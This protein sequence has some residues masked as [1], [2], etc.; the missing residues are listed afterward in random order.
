[1]QLFNDLYN[2]IL[3]L[4]SQNSRFISLPQLSCSVQTTAEGNQGA[5]FL[6]VAGN[7]IPDIR[8]V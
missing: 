1:M 4:P 6:G 5:V 8:L 2:A 3:L 7:K